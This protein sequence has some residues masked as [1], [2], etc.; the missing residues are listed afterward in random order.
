MCILNR[1]EM[2]LATVFKHKTVELNRIRYLHSIEINTGINIFFLK[3]NGSHTHEKVPHS[4][5]PRLT[6]QQSHQDFSTVVPFSLADSL[7]TLVMCLL[8]HDLLLTPEH[9]RSRPQASTKTFVSLSLIFR[10][11]VCQF[12]VR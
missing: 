6:P 10:E 4:S 12:V 2:R 5:P 11:T 3:K 1:I 8:L 9:I 7:R